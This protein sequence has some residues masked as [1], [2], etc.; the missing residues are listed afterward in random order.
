[1]RR[2]RR[3]ASNIE[4][5]LRG[6]VRLAEMTPSRQT[7]DDRHDAFAIE[8]EVTVDG[9]IFLAATRWSRFPV[10]TGLACYGI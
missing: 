6:E 3:I 2:G 1:M 5:T 9:T 10:S 8:P 7:G 4:K